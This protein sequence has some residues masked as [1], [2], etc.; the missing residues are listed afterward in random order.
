MRDAA[1]N[2]RGRANSSRHRARGVLPSASWGSGWWVVRTSRPIRS[3]TTLQA[4]SAA[5]DADSGATTQRVVRDSVVTI[6]FRTHDQRA[7]PNPNLKIEFQGGE[8]L[9]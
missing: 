6:N 7:A 9:L 5:R 3:P 8:P 4:N 1:R 2:R